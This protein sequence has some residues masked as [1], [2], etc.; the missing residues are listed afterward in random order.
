MVVQ[1]PAHAAGD[2]RAA[3]PRSTTISMRCSASSTYS[4][5]PLLCSVSHTRSW[6]NSWRARMAASS[7]PSTASGWSRDSMATRTSPWWPRSP[8]AMAAVISSSKLA[9]KRRRSWNQP[10]NVFASTRCMR[11]MSPAPRGTA[12]AAPAAA[13]SAAAETTE[14]A[15]A[16]TADRAPAA[17][18]QQH[19]DAAHHRAEHAGADGNQQPQ[20]AANQR[21]AQRHPYQRMRPAQ[22]AAQEDRGEQRD[23]QHALQPE[24]AILARRPFHRWRQWLAVNQLGQRADGVV[25]AAEI[26][27]RAELR[28]DV[29]ADDARVGGVGDRALQAITDLDA[30]APVVLGDEQQDAVI[31]ALAA[32]LVGFGDRQ[33]VLLD[34]LLAGA[35]HHQHHQLRTLG[36]FQRHQL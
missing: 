30:H 3:M 19:H 9:G 24:A 32:D 21:A 4:S 34:R 25:D 6:L 33:R 8:A 17:G 29:L 18:R 36:L 1:M 13:Q 2:T 35:A 26:V 20:Q 28:R 27:A 11:V 12:A 14:T 5:T 10:S 15:P 23:H 7:P 31:G 22:H 16:A